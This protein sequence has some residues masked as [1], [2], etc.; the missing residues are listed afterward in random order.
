MTS[1]QACMQ[2]PDHDNHEQFLEPL[3]INP[4]KSR[5]LKTRQ[6]LGLSGKRIG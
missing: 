3:E 4:P 5:S 1:Q 6:K 2:Q